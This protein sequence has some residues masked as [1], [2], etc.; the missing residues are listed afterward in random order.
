MYI[1]MR[2]VRAF[3]RCVVLPATPSPRVLH[4]SSATASLSPSMENASIKSRCSW[5]ADT[6]HHRPTTLSPNQAFARG[7]R[8]PGPTD[9]R[10]RGNSGK[11]SIPLAP[12]RGGSLRRAASPCI[13]T[14]LTTLLQRGYVGGIAPLSLYQESLLFRGDRPDGDGLRGPRV[15]RGM[16][17]GMGGGGESGWP[18]GGKCAG[19]LR[20]QS[21]AG[22]SGER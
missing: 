16:V 21:C 13:C 5:K 20:T 19:A 7:W 10:S 12:R 17:R 11:L 9:K 14:R 2:R 22:S 3:S 15:A 1:H 8:P 18:R 6:R 4:G